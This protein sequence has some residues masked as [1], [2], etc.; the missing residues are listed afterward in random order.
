MLGRCWVST[1]ERPL[2]RA[3]ELRTT[4]RGVWGQRVGPGGPTAG[5]PVLTRDWVKVLR[6]S[7][8]PRTADVHRLRFLWSRDHGWALVLALP[9]SL[10]L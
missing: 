10:Q 2:N 7:D 1:R 9:D 4:G 5:G 8:R 6:G 3:L